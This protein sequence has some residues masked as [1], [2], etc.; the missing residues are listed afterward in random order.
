[1]SHHQPL[2]TL[3]IETCKP[4]PPL[5]HLFVCVVVSGGAGA[6]GVGSGPEPELP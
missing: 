3:L 5:F 1:M 2:A 4:R 6:C